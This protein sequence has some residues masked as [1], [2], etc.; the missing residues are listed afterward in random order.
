MNKKQALIDLAIKQKGKPY[1]WGANGAYAFDC[2]GLIYWLVNQI[3]F[4]F[5]DATAETLYKSRCW[6]Q[7]KSALMPSDLVFKH[8]GA[9]IYHVGIYIGDNQVLEAKGKDYG[10]VISNFTDNNW[11]RYGRLKIFDNLPDVEIVRS[12]YYKVNVDDF[13]SLRAEPEAVSG[14]NRIKKLD[15]GA[16]VQFM[17]EEKMNGKFLWFMVSWENMI[18][19]V[20]SDWLEPY[21][22]PEAEAEPVEPTPP[23]L[24]Q[25]TKDNLL[26][27]ARQI[28]NR[29]NE[30][31]N[32]LI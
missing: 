24:S 10:V 14:D 13:L 23:Q 16:I 27:E 26:K 3:G 21:S 9:K 1:A 6:I 11:N 31:I 15:D 5:G 28:T 12:E 22:M 18:G 25:E 4:K 32:L 7:D 29:L 17:G 8:D 20:A 19:W 30:I 2:S